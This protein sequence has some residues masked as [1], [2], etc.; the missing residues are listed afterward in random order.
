[1]VNK[2][3]FRLHKYPTTET[4]N[5]NDD[6]RHCVGTLAF[7]Y[8][9]HYHPL[10]INPELEKSIFEMALTPSSLLLAF[11]FTEESEEHFV[12]LISLL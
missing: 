6:D 12:I 2:F 5:D 8:D 4:H 10:I 7:A 1:M 11:R 9:S 3:T